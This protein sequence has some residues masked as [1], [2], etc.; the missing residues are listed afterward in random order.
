MHGLSLNVN[1]DLGAF[2]VINLCGISGA[3]PTSVEQELGKSVTAQEVDARVMES[4]AEVFQVNLTPI[5]RQ[6]LEAA[7]FAPRALE[8]RGNA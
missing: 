4:F 2:G 6:Q 8:G 3:L 7:C 1:P 5:S